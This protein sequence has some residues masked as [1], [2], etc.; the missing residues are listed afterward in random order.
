VSISDTDSAVRVIQR[1]S[2]FLAS[3]G[4][5]AGS[6]PRVDR[7]L[8][9]RYLADLHHELRG[10]KAHTRHISA[11][12]VFLR[13]IRQHGWDPTLPGGAVFYPED[14]PRQAERLPRALAEQ[15]M[16]QLEQPGNLGRCD[17]P[18]YRLITLILMR[19]PW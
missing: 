19:C 11:L 16:A 4:V 12:N 2:A 17:N 10:R 14:Y 7:P 6:L 3:P 15:V 5:A 8:L 9:E 1:F 18:A 13:A